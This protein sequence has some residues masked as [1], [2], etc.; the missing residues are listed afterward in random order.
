MHPHTWGT[1]LEVYDLGDNYEEGEKYGPHALSY[2]ARPVLV[3]VL[4]IFQKSFWPSGA[5]FAIFRDLKSKIA[6]I[7]IFPQKNPIEK[8]NPY[9]I[10][11]FFTFLE[12]F[13][14][15]LEFLRLWP[16]FFFE[17]FKA[18]KFLRFEFF[19]GWSFSQE[20]YL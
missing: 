7:H 3:R 13:S 1:Y 15:S 6:M 9:K 14:R 10:V 4:N 20:R 8:L 19:L 11:F 2:S 12:I 16:T 5:L 18:L 17:K